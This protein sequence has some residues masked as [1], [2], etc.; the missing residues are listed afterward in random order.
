MMSIQNKII[1]F[2]AQRDVDEN[3]PIRLPFRLN[4]E[5]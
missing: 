5:F 4:V 1:D 2:I 3:L